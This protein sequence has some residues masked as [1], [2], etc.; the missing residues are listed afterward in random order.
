LAQ[1]QK[2]LDQSGATLQSQLDRLAAI[3]ADLQRAQTESRTL[4]KPKSA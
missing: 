3:T 2:A 4:Q 1:A